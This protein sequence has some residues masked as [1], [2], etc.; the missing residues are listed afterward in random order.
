M[1]DIERLRRTFLDLLAFNSPH[2]HEREVNRYCAEALREAGFVCQTDAAGNVIAQKAGTVPE[3]PRIFFSAHTDTVQPTEGLVVREVDGVFRTSGGTI[4]GAD[5][6]A[7]VAAILEAVRVL[8]ERRI[9]HGDLQ[10]ILTVGEE[11][12]LVGASALAPEVIAGSMGFVFDASGATGSVITSAPSHDLLDVHVVGRAAHAG[13]SPESGCSALRIAAR[14]IHHMRLGRIDLETTANVGTLRGGTA[15]NIVAEEAWV[16]LEARS[17]SLPALE[18]QV[19]H[20]REC[21]E[22]AARHFEGRVEIR[23]TREYQG[24]SWSR[25]DLPVRIAADA[26]RRS[27]GSEPVLRPHGGGS[28]A[29]VF[30]ARGIPTVVLSC[31]YRDAHSVN[32]HVP[33]SEIAAV[34]NWALAIAETAAA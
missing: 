14:A 27:T 9:P 28:D 4:L 20:M 29:N 23:H 26:W 31:G 25:N 33:L 2:P 5:D 13:N 16:T 17:R 3:A 34:A 6:K 10:V 30:N 24:Y 1:I 11:V 21:F 7:G 22:E 18:A 12:G 32:E 19:A 15:N 8:E